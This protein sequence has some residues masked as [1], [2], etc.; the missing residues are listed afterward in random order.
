MMGLVI[1]RLINF[2]QLF[3]QLYFF[4]ISKPNKE[5]FDELKYQIDFEFL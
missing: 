5:P 1:I 4:L 3:Y 2:R